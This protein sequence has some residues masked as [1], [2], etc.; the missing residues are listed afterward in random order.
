MQ[1]VPPVMI[2]RTRASGYCVA[3]LTL[4]LKLQMVAEFDSGQRQQALKPC[5]K[6][7]TPV[8]P[9]ENFRSGSVTAE[10]V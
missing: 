4:L 2:M 3:I 8:S 9:D 6:I 1:I 10:A 5:I 7:L